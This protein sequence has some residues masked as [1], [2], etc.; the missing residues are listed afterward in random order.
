M[1]QHTYSI[2]S[3]DR[4]QVVLVAVMKNKNN[5]LVSYASADLFN[6]FKNGQQ[7]PATFQ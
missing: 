4:Q 2:F 5:Q 6:I 1:L 3:A 7:V